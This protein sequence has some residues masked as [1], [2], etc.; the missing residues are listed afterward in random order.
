MLGGWFH[1]EEAIEPA[2]LDRTTMRVI[3]FPVLSLICLGAVGGGGCSDAGGMTPA[4]ADAMRHPV[5]DPNYKGPSP[6]ASQKMQSQIEA[7]RQKHQ[8]DKVEFKSGQ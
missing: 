4:Q 1:L 8:N 5:V 6:E 3:N 2:I 7:Y